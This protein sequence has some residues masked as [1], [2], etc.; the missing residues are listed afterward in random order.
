MGVVERG[1]YIFGEGIV[2]E[3]GRIGFGIEY[4]RSLGV[5]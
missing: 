3:V 2:G 1:E 4:W 5:K